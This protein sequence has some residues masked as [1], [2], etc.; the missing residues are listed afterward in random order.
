[1]RFTEFGCNRREAE[2]KS[3]TCRASASLM[4][5]LDTLRT[6]NFEEPFIALIGTPN[7]ERGTTVCGREYL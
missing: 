4:I 6:R 1:M 7:M 2:S 3:N 5:G